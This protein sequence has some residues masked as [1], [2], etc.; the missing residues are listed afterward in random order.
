MTVPLVRLMQFAGV[1]G[2]L[3]PSPLSSLAFG[4]LDGGSEGDCA[5]CADYPGR[6]G[7]RPAR[8]K[9]TGDHPLPRMP[10]RVLSLNCG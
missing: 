4:G 9:H 6:A 5:S 1:A 7:P 8:V 3:R 10:A 2:Q